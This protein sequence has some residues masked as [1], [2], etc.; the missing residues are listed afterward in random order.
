MCA[1]NQCF[2][3]HIWSIL[4]QYKLIDWDIELQM[5]VTTRGHVLLQSATAYVTRLAR[6]GWKLE[7]EQNMVAYRHE[8]VLVFLSPSSLRRDNLTP[9]FNAVMIWISLLH[10][11][12]Q[13]G[14]GRQCLLIE[15]VMKSDAGWYTL[16]AINVAGMS[17]CNA[18]LDIGSKSTVI[19]SFFSLQI[20][21]EGPTS[22]ICCM[23]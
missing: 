8:G 16:S 4:V 11:L 3:I 20:R 18:R 1:K 13:D 7:F 2:N 17:T 9:M 23:R 15:K 22:A 10:S 5:I 21:C 14:S 12:Y 6:Y 19:V